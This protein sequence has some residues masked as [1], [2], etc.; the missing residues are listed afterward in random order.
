MDKKPKVLV[1]DDEEIS[2]TLIKS[3][4]NRRNYEVVEASSGEDAL[5]II[6]NHNTIDV[7]LLDIMMPGLDGFEVLE[8]IK[9][10]SDTE[11]IKVIMLT[12]M[13]QVEEKVRAFSSGASDYLIKPFEREELIARVETQVTL[14]RVEEN[15]EELVEERTNELKIKDSQLVQSAKL[16]S[17]G[18]MAAGIAHEINQPLTVIKITTTG[19]LRHMEK[20]RKISEEMLRGELEVTDSQIE[21][22]RGIIDH[23]RTF[24]R[25]SSEV[26]KE[27]VDI[28]VPLSDCFKII[29]EQLKLRGVDIKLDLDELPMVLADSN[30]LEQVFLNLIGNAKDAMDDFSSGENYKKILNVHSFRE[31]GNVVVTISDTGGGI[32]KE[33]QNKVF[34]PFFTTKEVG[35]GTGIGLSISYNIIKDFDGDLSF[36]VEEGVGTTFI[37]KIPIGG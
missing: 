33:V 7:I 17:L 10:N 6:E 13:T 9:S 11:K 16:A 31:N 25:R 37:V 24:A 23:L 14:K 22:I 20:G 1:V 15:L 26:Q 5:V 32:P 36:S 27:L 21:R 3:I 8:Y 2:R 18:E 28:N 4:L 19:L 30:K 29:G 35:K 34:E 12:A